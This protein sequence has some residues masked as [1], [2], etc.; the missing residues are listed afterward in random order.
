MIIFLTDDEKT[1]SFL[2][3]SDNC[4]VPVE[5]GPMREYLK[6]LKPSSIHDLS[7][8]NA[9]YRPG[10]MDFMMILLKENKAA[11]VEYLHPVLEPILK[12][13]YGIIVYQEQ[14]IQIANRVAG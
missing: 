5:S 4:S 2:Q 11:K 6:K 12:E 7:A 13:T 9:L 10:P 14:V 8:M 3:R 1:T